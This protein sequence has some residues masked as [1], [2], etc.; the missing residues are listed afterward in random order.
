MKKTVIVDGNSLLFRAYYSTAY[1]GSLM[2]NKDGIPTN[3]IFSF[4]NFMKK[5]KEMVSLGDHLF[6]AF[7]F[8]KD[9]KRKKE[10]KDYK[11]QRKKIDDNLLIQMPIAREMLNSMDIYYS[12]KEGYEGDDLC[13]SIA[14]IAVENQEDVLIFTSDKDFLQLCSLSKRVKIHFL[15]KG[16][17]EVEIFDDDNMMEKFSLPSSL[18]TDYKGMAGDSSDNYKGIPGIGEKTSKKLLNEYGSLENI[19]KEASKHPENKTFKKILDNQEDALFF[20]KLAMIDTDMDIKDEFDKSIY[21]PYQKDKLRKFY[22]KYQ[23]NSFIKAM[24]KMKDIKDEQISIFSLDEKDEKQCKKIKTLKEIGDLDDLSVVFSSNKDNENESSLS[25]FY[26]AKKDDVFFISL[27]DC[28]ND[29]SFKEYLCSKNKKSV[30]DLKALL[31]LLKRNDL[32]DIENVDFDFLLATYLLDPDVG[33]KKEDIFFSYQIDLNSFADPIAMSA[34]YISEFKDEV[35]E[36]LKK[37]ELYSLFVDVEIPLSRVLASMEIEGFPMDKDTLLLLDKTYSERLMK[38]KEEICSLSGKEFNISSPKQ[39]E[40]VLFKDMN[41][42]RKKGEKGTSI[43]VLSSHVKDHPIFKKII[44]YRL[45]SKIVNSYTKALPKHVKEDGKIHA[46]YNQALTST[47]RLSMSEPN[48][49]NI[50][51][52]NE[53]GKNIR[54]AFY[55]KEDDISILSLDY[56]QIELRILASVADIKLLKELFVEGDDIHAATASKVFDVPLAEVTS[57][58]RRKAKAVNFGIVYGISP[59]GLSEQ[60]AISPVEAKELIEQFKETFIGLDEFQK[61]TIDFASKNTYVK[62]ILG[63]RR[64]LKDINS[65]NFA[66]RSFSQRAATN[67]VIQGSAADLIKVGMIKCQDILSSFKSKIILQI[68][69]ELLF[70]IYDDEKDILL[71]KLKYAMENALKIDVPLKVDGEIKK[72]W[73]EAH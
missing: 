13:G 73:Y 36:R 39:L 28:K 47:G 26:L 65:S 45:Y 25:G 58:M 30:Y 2:T 27:E 33:Q 8:G 51:I 15:R 18:I 4:H 14:K 66:L 60:L 44:D 16:L 57:D 21:S 52:R 48:L 37:D 72:T 61:K 12:E 41:I 67:A 20:K 29:N 34:F 32:P 49:Q 11:A 64:Y 35:I 42:P 71:P 68:H 3:A 24:D 46:I 5:I 63:R 43:E 62:T 9:T 69:D 22:T 19:I 55:Y 17:S 50:S 7:D 54:K 56:S 6:V 53:E 1:S 40:E 38:I 70:K 10:F 59:Y 31:V 23:F